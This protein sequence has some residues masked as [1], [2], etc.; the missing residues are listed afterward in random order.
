VWRARCARAPR[1]ARLDPRASSHRGARAQPAAR[2][3]LDP[4]ASIRLPPDPLAAQ[5]LP[6]GPASQRAQAARGC[7]HR[8]DGQHQGGE[9]AG[10]GAEGA[11]S[12]G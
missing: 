3:C 7:S 5:A 12:L 11:A 8:R 10:A 9:H 2:A 4:R 6:N 1:S